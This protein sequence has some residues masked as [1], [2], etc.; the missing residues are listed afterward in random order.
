MPSDI[1]PLRESQLSIEDRV[2]LFTHQRPAD[3]GA[4][5]FLPR[6]G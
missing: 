1:I 5:H 6:G 4:F 2:A 3:L